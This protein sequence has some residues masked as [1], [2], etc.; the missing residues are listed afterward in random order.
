MASIIFL[1][2]LLL[3]GVFAF[4]GLAKLR[5]PRGSR[6]SLLDFGVPAVLAPALAVLL[7]LAELAGATALLVTPFAAGG[8]SGVAALLALFAAAVS[9]NLARGRAPSCQCFGQLSSSPVSWRTLVRNAVLL[10]L[11]VL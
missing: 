6:K 5:D 10:V 9:I 4:A 7:P 11:A 1:S 3:A 8:A 2:R